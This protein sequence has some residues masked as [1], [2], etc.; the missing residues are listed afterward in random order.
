[1]IIIFL[2]L[3]L[4][5]GSFL[6]AVVYRLNAVESL[7]ERSHCPHCKKTVRWFDNVPLLSFI[8]LSARCRDCGEKISWQYPVVE[9]STGIVFAMLG[10]YFFNVADFS[11]WTLTA[12]YL[13]IFSILMIIFVYDFKYMEIPMLILWLGVGVSLIY[14][15][16]ADWQ[17]FSGAA[18]IFDLKII[19]GIL[20]GLVAG[21]FFYNLAAYSKETWMGYGDAY[22]GLLAGLIIGWPNILI[23]L[24]LSFSIGALISVILVILNKKTVKSQVPFAPFLIGGVF[25]V[26]LLPQ[27]FPQLQ[28]YFLLFS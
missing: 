28:Y 12:Y 27:I 20:G 21:G 22:L 6:N 23:A 11:T 4:I 9:A 3:G 25:L 16:F 7:M 13:V 19:S 8:L 14:F 5:I 26:L 1:M 18:S 15:L 17:N 10:N 2:I 24:M